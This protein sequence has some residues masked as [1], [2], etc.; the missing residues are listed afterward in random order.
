M[1]S[2]LII[3]L[4]E[5]ANDIFNIIKK[6]GYSAFGFD[7]DIDKILF[8]KRNNI[9][10]NSSDLL[11][12]DLLKQADIIILNIDFSKYENIIK[13]LPFTKNDCLILNTNIYKE[14][15]R[16]IK[17]SLQNRTENFMPCNFLL[18]P[19]TVV[20]NQDETYKMNVI[21]KASN[22]FKSININTSTLSPVDND[23]I[24]CSLYQIP[25]L[26]QKILFKNTD[27]CLI[28]NDLK[29]T[30]YD[31]FY[32]DILLNKSN[33]ISKLDAFLNNLSLIKEEDTLFD[34]IDN[35]E[36]QCIKEKDENVNKNNIITEEIILKI[37]TEKVFIKTFI[38]RDIEYFLDIKNMN[39][40]YI[41][42]NNEDIKE[43]FLS[44]KSNIEVLSILVKEKI[45]NLSSLLQFD[46]FP[47]DKL[48]KYLRN[49]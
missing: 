34:L 33:I 48:I 2:V 24:F 47:L 3:G 25:F 20:M 21:L 28:K 14:N 5:L 35:Y 42:Y 41:K 26:L 49:F 22:F 30:K 10:E 43:Y 46:D 44:H 27:F 6:F 36:I 17:E 38:N 7:F 39:F 37:L 11:L 29:Y 4:N 31:F 45:I 13:A 8:Y 9:I 32:R 12:Q 23:E 40:D 19:H 1:S 15:S 18:F 16:Q